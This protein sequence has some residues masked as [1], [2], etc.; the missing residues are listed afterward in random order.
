MKKRLLGM[1]LIAC[2]MLALL[3]TAVFAGSTQ[4]YGIEILGQPV[5]DENCNDV[6]GDGGS[7]K[8]EYDDENDKGILTLTNA[9]ISTTDNF[10]INADDIDTLEIVLVGENRVEAE[11]DVSIVANDLIFSG[12]GS[13]AI[14]CGEYAAGTPAIDCYDSIT[15]NSGNVTVTGKNYAVC[16]D[17]TLRVNAGTLTL[18]ATDTGEDVSAIQPGFD[19]PSI[20][21]GDDRIMITSENSDG[22][23]AVVTEPNDNTKISAAKYV[24]IFYKY[25][26]VSIVTDDSSDP[27][28]M[29]AVYGNPIDK[30][31]VPTK[32]G[33]KFDGWYTDPECTMPYDFE[34][35]VT[36]PVTLYAKWT[37]DEQPAIDL[38]WWA[39]LLP[40]LDDELPF[41]DV[42]AGDWFYDDVR[43]VYEN[44][45]M[46]GTGAA[47]FRPNAA[48]TRGMVLTILARNEGVDTSGTPW[49]AAGRDWAVANGISDGTNMEAPVTRE[50]LAAMLYRYASFKG[51]DAAAP[52]RDLSAF[53]DADSVSGWALE[54]MRWAVDANLISGSN[55]NLRPQGTATRAELAAL[56]SRFLG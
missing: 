31:A 32:D 29:N 49:Y 22:T 17:G 5:D 39:G 43:Y 19:P 26:T 50:Q 37:K 4:G 38:P 53:P 35:K 42:N 44:S 24:K 11:E 13:I 52:E 15:V 51:R 14:A 48:V 45:L 21:L 8:F 27:D 55:G 1:L 47:E 34:T 25:V 54:A 16:Y 10:P 33:Y 2:M 7:V 36:E 20:L 3:P 56:L 6:L 9:T 23:D 28:T 12:E 46:H 18:I 41:A 30:P 40:V